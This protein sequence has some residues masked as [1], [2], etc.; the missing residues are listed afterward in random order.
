MKRFFLFSVAV[1]TLC[2]VQSVHASVAVDSNGFKQGTAS[3]FVQAITI[4]SGESLWVYVKDDGSNVTAIDWNG[5]PLTLI[6]DDHLNWIGDETYYLANPTPASA[7][8]SVTFA[9]SNIYTML[10]AVVGGADASSPLGAHSNCVFPCD[11]SPIGTVP[12]TI[13]NAASLSLG[14]I[15]TNGNTLPTATGAW[16][17]LDAPYQSADGTS[18]MSA[19]SLAGSTGVHPMT[20]THGGT[21]Y[22]GLTIEVLPASSPPPPT[23]STGSVCNGGYGVLATLPSIFNGNFAE[24]T[25]VDATSSV[26]WTQCMILA[27]EVT[28]Y[29]FFQHGNTYAAWWAIMMVVFFPLLAISLF[30]K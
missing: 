29:S 9:G 16:A 13:T 14:F 30:F 4:S 1:F 24:I 10:Y 8:L 27:S 3:S 18:P 23:P 25:G 7:N 20:F 6:D 5:A 22:M 19:W 17:T 21:G 2:G 28:V 11:N 12:L 26:G 15:T